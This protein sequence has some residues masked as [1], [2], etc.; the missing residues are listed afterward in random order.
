MKNRYLLPLM[1]EL[2]ES[3]NT[4]KVFTKLDL[5]NGYHLVYMAEEDEEQIAF[6]TRFGLYHWRVMPFGLC[7]APAML[8]SMMDNIFRDLLNN[9]VIVY[10]DEI[11]IHTQNVDKHVLLVREVLSR[12]NKANLIVNLKTSVFHLNKV[13]FLGYIISE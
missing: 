10:L 1:P 9:G 11:M 8:Q 7:N 3:L 12:L 5:E 13:E 4:A 6:C 2:R